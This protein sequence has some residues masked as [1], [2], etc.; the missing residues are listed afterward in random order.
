VNFDHLV[1][2]EVSKVRENGATSGVGVLATYA[3]DDQG[4]RIAR[5]DPINVVDPLGLPGSRFCCCLSPPFLSWGSRENSGSR[6][7]A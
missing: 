2:G 1:T 4:R 7:P 6:E 3:Y 5:R